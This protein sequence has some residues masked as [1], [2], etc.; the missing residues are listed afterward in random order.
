MKKKI[1]ILFLLCAVLNIIVYFFSQLLGAIISIFIVVASIAFL[2]I[3][4]LNVLYKKTNNWNNRFVFKDNFISG[5]GYRTKLERNFSIINLGSNPALYGFFYESILGQNWATGSQGLEMDYEILRFYHS[6]LKSGGVVLIPIMPFTAVSQYIKYKKD[7]W[8]D[9]Y[10]LKFASILS[11]MQTD[12]LPNGKKLKKVLRYPLLFNPKLIKYLIVDDSPNENLK[13][14]EQTMGKLELEHDANRMISMWLREFDAK[15][16][17][18]FNENKYGPYYLESQRIL[19]K[20][21]DFCIERS[22]K[23][24]LIT[25]PSTQILRD[26]FDESFCKYMIT[27]FVNGLSN[28][29]VLF[30]NYMNEKTFMNDELFNGSFYLNLRGRKVFTKQVLR[31]LKLINE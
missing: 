6:Y 1:A 21:I 2:I 26:R 7:Y 4:I 23:P 30:L 29:D 3:L 9:N 24:V 10:Y 13:T 20:I 14:S 18:D 8:D 12:E 17:M 15:S 5:Q 25:I 31:D 22:Y 11:G 16:L 27:D 19:D 28:K